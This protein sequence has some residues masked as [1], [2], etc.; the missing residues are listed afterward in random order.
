M[1]S[2][3]F[4]PLYGRFSDIFGRKAAICM[5]MGRCCWGRGGGI[6]GMMQIIISDIITLRERGKY[7]GI[8]GGVVAIGYTI[9]PIIGGL[10]AQKVSWRW[11]FWITL[12]LSLFATT[13]VVV[14][15]PLKPVQGDMKK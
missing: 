10:L 8:I 5:A 11:C 13:V 6:I 14:V 3:A 15:L 2:T 7:Q 9:G 12:P 4:Q 1:T